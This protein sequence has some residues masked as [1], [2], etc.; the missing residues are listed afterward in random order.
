[1][2]GSSF[3]V[4]LQQD[5]EL[6]GQLVVILFHR[7]Q[8]KLQDPDEGLQSLGNHLMCTEHVSYSCIY[9]ITGV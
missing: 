5:K 8:R 1:M 4:I 7:R 3:G 6:L 9:A 2:A